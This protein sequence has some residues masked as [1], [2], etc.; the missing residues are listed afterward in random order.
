ML[1][2]EGR[3]RSKQGAPP[4]RSLCHQSHTSQ[5]ISFH[6]LDTIIALDP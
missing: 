6:P 5:T 1:T 4:S 2:G 3:E